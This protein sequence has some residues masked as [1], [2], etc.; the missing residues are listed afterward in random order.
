[1]KNEHRSNG[2]EHVWKRVFDDVILRVGQSKRIHKSRDQNHEKPSV[3]KWTTVS[4]EYSRVSPRKDILFFKKKRVFPADQFSR[5]NSL[6]ERREF[7]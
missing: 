5:D 4:K 2:Y 1:M 3:L 7:G 6:E